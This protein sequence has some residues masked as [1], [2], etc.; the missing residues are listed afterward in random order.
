MHFFAARARHDTSALGRHQNGKGLRRPGQPSDSASPSNGKPWHVPSLSLKSGNTVSKGQR[1]IP[2]N[3]GSFYFEA[4]PTTC[5][6][7][8]IPDG[9]RRTYG[10][11]I[12]PKL[13]ACSRNRLSRLQSLLQRPLRPRH[14]GI[15]FLW[16]KLYSV[17]SKQDYLL[18]PGCTLAGIQQHPELERTC[19][20]RFGMLR[21]PANVNR[22]EVSAKC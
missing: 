9:T 18:A 20:D 6:M 10:P 19:T 4:V 11:Q 15:M 1:R 22:P 13:G 17:S 16:M 3:T 12:W 14:F 8:R 7:H 2:V 21:M 5:R